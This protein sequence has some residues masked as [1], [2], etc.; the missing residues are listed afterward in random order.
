MPLEEKE[1]TGRG[2]MLGGVIDCNYAAKD[3]SH[4]T[5]EKQGETTPR[6]VGEHISVVLSDQACVI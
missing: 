5:L 2:R 1:D 6:T 4:Q 3:L